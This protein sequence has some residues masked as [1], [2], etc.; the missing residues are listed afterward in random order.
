MEFFYHLRKQFA[1]N[2]SLILSQFFALYGP[3]IVL[4]HVYSVFFSVNVRNA[5]GGTSISRVF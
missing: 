4:M 3:I 5:G 1:S 2:V